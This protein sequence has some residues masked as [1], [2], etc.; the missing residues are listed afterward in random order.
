MSTFE[1][2]VV[3]ATLHANLAIYCLSFDVVSL[4]DGGGG[5]CIAQDCVSIKIVKM[6]KA[7]TV[8][9]IEAFF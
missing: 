2:V 8:N 4:I 6:N 1:D 5:G 3:A 9:E 7:Q